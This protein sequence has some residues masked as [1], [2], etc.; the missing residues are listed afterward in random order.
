MA[1]TQTGS[2]QATACI[3]TRLTCSRAAA[4]AGSHASAFVTTPHPPKAAKPRIPVRYVAL[5]HSSLALE[6]LPDR[7]Q[8]NSIQATEH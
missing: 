1:S 3:G 4:H 6:P 8:P 2:G 7:C 5:D